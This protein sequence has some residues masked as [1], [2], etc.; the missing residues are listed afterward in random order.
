MRDIRLEKALNLAKWLIDFLGQDFAKKQKAKLRK[1]QQMWGDY[2]Y[3]ASN[4]HPLLPSILYYE[5]WTPQYDTD[6]ALLVPVEILPL[7][8]VAYQIQLFRK[9][10][11]DGP[12]GRNTTCLRTRL[13]AEEALAMLFE[14]R[15]ATHYLLAGYRTELVS[16]KDHRAVDVLVQTPTATIEIECKSRKSGSGRKVPDELFNQLVG[17]IGPA[18]QRS[19]NIYGISLECVDRLDSRHLHEIAIGISRRIKRDEIGSFEPMDRA[20]WVEIK[21]LGPKGARIPLERAKRLLE[22]YVDDRQRPCHCAL[23][24]LPNPDDDPIQPVNPMYFVTRSRKPDSVLDRILEVSSKGVSQL[25]GTCPGIVAIHIPAPIDRQDLQ[26]LTRSGALY[27]AIC[28]EFQK[29][30]WAKVSAVAF[31][32]EGPVP[33][34]AG[35][36]GNHLVL[37]YPNPNADMSLPE[38]FKVAM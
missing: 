14:L 30:K 33:I 18:V 3:L 31:V 13:R 4:L 6:G 35:A 7:A 11:D 34:K 16:I 21:K 2:A 27:N 5:S 8:T 26:A 38:G 36:L 23:G 17:M 32:A 24:W 22:P 10:W 28:Q 15:A 9:D 1:V 37:V 12:E 19:E 25:S 20:Y 29:R